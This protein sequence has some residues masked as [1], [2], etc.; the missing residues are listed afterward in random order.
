MQRIIHMT[1]L[2]RVLQS[3]R[4]NRIYIWRC[5]IGTGSRGY[6]GWNVPQ[7]T[8]CKLEK[9][10]SCNSVW[11]QRPE[12]YNA[13]ADGVSPN[14]SL[15]AQEPG[16][17]TSES[18]RR[19]ISQLKHRETAHLLFLCLFVLYG[20]SVDWM[21]PTDIGENYLLYS[22]HQFKCKSLPETLLQ[23]HPEIVFY[24]LSG[25]PLAQSSWHI[26]LITTMTKWCL[27][28][29]LTVSPVLENQSK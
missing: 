23:T 5:I 4:T 19:W 13:E 7:S 22:V 17:P 15:K 12:N 18:R 24:Q 10:E 28:Q 20:P 16:A 29:G 27:F 3:K 21:I 25:Q 6:D 2:V 8:I 9:Q 14:M 26:K 11:I 1:V